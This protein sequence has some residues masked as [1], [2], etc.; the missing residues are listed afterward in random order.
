M[1]DK[2]TMPAVLNFAPAAGSVELR[3]LEIPEI[4][5]SD[6]LLQVKAVGIC[7]SDLHQY[8]GKQSW[9][10][11][12]PVTLGH[13]FAGVIAKTGAQV[14][15]FKQGDRV[16]SETAAVL[17]AQSPF[18]R[19]GQYN[20]DPNRLGFGYGVHGAMTQFVRVPERCLHRVPDALDF[21]KA[22]LTEP[23]CVAYNAVCM[24]TRLRP[25]DSV[26]IIGPGPIG[27]L[28][29]LMAKL[30]GANPLIVIG[31][32]S[33]AKRLNVAREI[34]A[35]Q[36]FGAQGENVAEQVLALGD[37]Y[38]VDAVIDAAG[39]SATLQLAMQIVR[40]GGQITKVGWGPQPCDFSLDP[41]VQKG[42][43]LQGS[44]SHN[45][46]MWERVIAMLASG[47]INLEPILNR[48]APLDEWQSCFEQMQSGDVVKAVLV[49]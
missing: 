21:E 6:V 46:P 40:P 8:H 36:V 9:K 26:A 1:S 44:F 38:G 7:G 45:W 13:E 29:A 48:V 35:T 5:D 39:V 42:V 22:A 30:C 34:G 3:E 31:T 43:T 11:N 27:L 20:L 33:D 14:L 47:Q 41:L 28:C 19:A 32:T 23:C 4:G 17:D 37:G 16:V 2:T 10:V 15:A 49:P 24:N 25:G 12:Y 18:V